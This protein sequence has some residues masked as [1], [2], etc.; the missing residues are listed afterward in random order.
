MLLQG[1][2][3]VAATLLLAM[4]GVSEVE[5]EERAFWLL[6]A[7]SHHIV[8]NYYSDSMVNV[9]VDCLVFEEL[10]KQAFLLP[11]C[12]GKLNDWN[13]VQHNVHA[14]NVHVFSSCF[15]KLT[16]GDGF[17]NLNPMLLHFRYMPYNVPNECKK[18]TDFVRKLKKKGFISPQEGTAQF[19]QLLQSTFVPNVPEAKELH[20]YGLCGFLN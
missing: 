10:L 14:Q 19:P 9:R 12:L 13:Y 4:Q 17:E 2:N 18:S 3:Y 1:L 5:A 20:F 7:L 15:Q 11:L 8:P 16:T 6:Y